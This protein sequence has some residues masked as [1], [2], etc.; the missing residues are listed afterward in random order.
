MSVHV[1]KLNA[2]L[3]KQKS[4]ELENERSMSKISLQKQE[5][6]NLASFDMPMVSNDSILAP[7]SARSINRDL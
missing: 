5:I 1:A 2:D 6:Q 3:L 7:F 4:L